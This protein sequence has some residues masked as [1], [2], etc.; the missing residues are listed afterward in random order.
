V[1]VVLDPLDIVLAEIAAGLYFDE[2]E[3]DLAGIFSGVGCRLARRSIHF[4]AASV[5]S[6]PRSAKI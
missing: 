3:I 5:L 1:I 6:S 4:R 2:F